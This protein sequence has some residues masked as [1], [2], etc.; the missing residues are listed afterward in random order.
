ME[1]VGAR[2]KGKPP[3][4]FINTFLKQSGANLNIATIPAALTGLL[5]RKPAHAHS[6]A[7]R[8]SFDPLLGYSN[9]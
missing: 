8:H 7:F 2:K 6:H 1:H 5:T 9:S 4:M 3:T